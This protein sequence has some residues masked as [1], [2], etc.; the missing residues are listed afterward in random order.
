[1]I[2]RSI[3]AF[4]FEENAA[5]VARKLFGYCHNTSYW[6][7]L[8][9]NLHQSLFVSFQIDFASVWNS[10]DWWSVSRNSLAPLNCGGVRVPSFIGNSMVSH[11]SESCCRPTTSTTHRILVAIKD[12]LSWQWHVGPSTSKPILGDRNGRKNPARSAVKLIL[13]WLKAFR[14]IDWKLKKKK[15]SMKIQSFLNILPAAGAEAFEITSLTLSFKV[16]L[17]EMISP[18]LPSWIWVKFKS[19]CHEVPR[20]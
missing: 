2:W 18:S 1:M 12:V 4:V 8:R 11:V 10:E 7:N 15:I 9:K 19:E 16:E 5:F 6:S 20:E 14:V 13:S 3:S 17:F